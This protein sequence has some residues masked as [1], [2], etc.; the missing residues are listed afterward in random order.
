MSQQFPERYTSRVVSNLPV[1]ETSYEIVIERAGLNFEAGHEIMIHGD[2]PDE[3]RQYSIAS[4]IAEEHLHIL[5]RV[6][7][8]GLMTPKL[9]QK[10]AGDAI[11]FTGAIG[12]FL[13]RDFLAPMVFVATGT[14]IAPAAWFVR[15]HQG[16]NL[17]LLH[18]VR[19]VQDLFYRDQ[20]PPETYHACIS[21]E[22]E[23]TE[24]FKG[25]VTHFLA[26][27]V[28]PDDTHYYLCGSNDMILE[29]RRM[30]KDRNVPDNQI[31]TEAYYFW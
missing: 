2:T 3:D 24:H 1:C 25:R 22:V 8:D 13:I 5:Y 14:G 10:Q 19:D 17:T 20:F 7:P 31:F 15:S 29:T 28:Y 27:Q 18:G 12:S 9:K 6:I 11:E 26:D 30:L 4:G 21:G 16:L 23:D